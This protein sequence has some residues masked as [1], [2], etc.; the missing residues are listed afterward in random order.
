MVLL[1][2]NAIPGRT[3]R[4][5]SKFADE[6]HV[7]FA[8]AK[9]Y[10]SVPVHVSGNPIRQDLLDVIPHRE[11]RKVPQRNVLVIGGSQGANA[12]NQAI[13]AAMP[14]LERRFAKEPGAGVRVVHL[15]GTPQFWT[16]LAAHSQSPISAGVFPFCEHMDRLYRHADLVV[17]RAGATTLAEVNALGIPSIM[18]P[19][20]TAADDH[21]TANARDVEAA[22]AGILI[23]EGDL[24]G[25]L[26]VTMADMLMSP[27]RLG[28]MA[29]ASKKL[30]RPYAAQTVARRLETLAG[31]PA[32]ADT[33]T[34]QTI[35]VAERAA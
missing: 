32:I 2:Q 8:S 11:E 7:Q 29:N 23:Q 35:S 13:L 20:P 12:V 6:V 9:D 26:A 27:L 22:G 30:G 18:I 10:L 28:G 16:C 24:R 15:S 19:Y 34:A 3:N 17:C 1:E 21:Q 33:N 5:L 4:F 31:R 14:K 25:K